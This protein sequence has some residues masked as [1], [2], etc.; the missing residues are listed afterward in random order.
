M[1]AEIELNNE[2]LSAEALLFGE[3]PS[4]IVV[5]FAASNLDK[6]RELAGDHPFEV[7]GRVGG[8]SLSIS[9]NGEIKY[10][11]S[12]NKLESAWKKSLSKLLEN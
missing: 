12:I 7:I 11:E 8:E 3:T 4:R 1:G 10:T 5:S 6:V 2:E 9:L